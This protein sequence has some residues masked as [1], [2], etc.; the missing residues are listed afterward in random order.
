MII[1]ATKKA[2]M[3]KP[4]PFVTPQATRVMPQ[5]WCT[6]CA[7]LS[8]MV[9]LEEANQLISGQSC[10]SHKTEKEHDIQAV[11]QGHQMK[12]S[13]GVLVVCLHA[14]FPNAF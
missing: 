1:Q 3:D 4:I 10:Q 7:K 5:L 9:T 11:T 6:A 2:V 13:S 12:L 14:L 8:W